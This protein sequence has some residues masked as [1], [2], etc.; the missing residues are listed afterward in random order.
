VSAGHCSALTYTNAR[1][2]THSHTKSTF[3]THTHTHTH[4]H[5]SFCTPACPPAH[6]GTHAVGDV[7]KCSILPSLSLPCILSRV[8]PRA[9]SLLAGKW[10]RQER[11]RHHRG[12]SRIPVLHTR[13]S[14]TSRSRCL[15]Q[16]VCAHATLL[17][18]TGAGFARQ[19]CRRAPLAPAR[20]LMCPWHIR[21]A[22]RERARERES[23]R[24]R[25]RERERELY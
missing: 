4:T 19:M 14:G 24:E 11:L 22:E 13:R 6:V 16:R 9:P 25:E 18:G 7:R 23:E 5:S 2:H 3:C 8:F 10:R 21:A 20:W 1:A 17:A 15:R 12:T